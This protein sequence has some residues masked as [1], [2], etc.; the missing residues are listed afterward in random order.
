MAILIIITLFFY[1]GLQK[2]NS[3]VLMYDQNLAS[4]NNVLL[5]KTTHNHVYLQDTLFKLAENG[6]LIAINI[7]DV[8]LKKE[9]GK[10]SELSYDENGKNG[11][12][13][14]FTLLRYLASKGLTKDSLGFSSLTTND[15]FNIENGISFNFTKL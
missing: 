13:I 1:L 12:N 3:D 14:R 2:I 6:N 5:T 8:E 7:S 4:P 9:W 11:N 10:R 15:V